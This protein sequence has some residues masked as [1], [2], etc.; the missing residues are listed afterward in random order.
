MLVSFAN[1]R[2]LRILRTSSISDCAEKTNGGNVV[3]LLKDYGSLSR[4]QERNPVMLLLISV[5]VLHVLPVVFK[6]NS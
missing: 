5:G 3:S 6:A 1:P 4:R 2:D